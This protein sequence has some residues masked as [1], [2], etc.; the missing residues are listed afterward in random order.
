MDKKRPFPG[1]T[2]PAFLIGNSRLAL[3]ARHIRDIASSAGRKEV[4][5][6][7][8]HPAKG[9][10]GRRYADGVG[11]RVGQMIAMASR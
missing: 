11:L 5:S 10:P 4:G 8:E 6:V 7:G 3:L 2:F 9:W 1:Y